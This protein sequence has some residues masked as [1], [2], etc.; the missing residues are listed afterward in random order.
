MGEGCTCRG[1]NP[2]DVKYTPTL[3]ASCCLAESD[4]AICRVGSRFRDTKSKENPPFPQHYW[5]EIIY[6]IMISNN[7]YLNVYSKQRL[8]KNYFCLDLCI[9][10]IY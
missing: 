1:R 5:L 10:G 6:L 2:V 8:C 3:Q 7:K 4:F 9:I